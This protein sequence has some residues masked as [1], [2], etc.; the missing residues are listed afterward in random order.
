MHK[1]ACVFSF[2]MSS[3]VSCQKIVF[4]LHK[5]WSLNTK[6]TLLNFNYSSELRPG[7]VLK[8]VEEIYAASPEVIVIMDHKPH[9]LAL[10]TLL[11]EKY[12]DAKK[13]PRFIF[14]IFGDFTLYYLEW[15]SLSTLLKNYKVDFIVASPRQKLLIDKM[16]LPPMESY[17]CPFPVDSKEFNYAPQN[18]TAQRKSWGVTDKEM[19]FVF[20]GRLTLQKRIHT[21]IEQFA[22]VVR[23]P[24]YANAHLFLYGNTDDI[25]DP[26]LGK[27]ET[28]GE[29]F[30]LLD[31][32]YCSLE[33]EV[34]KKIHFMGNVSNHEL[35][36]VYQGADVLVN[37]SVHNDEDFGMSVAE[38]QASG[39]P[40]ILTDWGG[41]AGFATPELGAATIFVPVEIGMKSKIVSKLEVRRSLR[42]LLRSGPSRQRRKISELSLK[43]FDVAAAQEK[44]SEIYARKPQPFDD[45]SPL[46][47]KI[48]T[49]LKLHKSLYISRTSHITHTYREI[50]SAYVSGN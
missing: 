19:A 27:W 49:R 23:K 46:F 48:H 45:F 28:P 18:R 30:R 6:L 16:L 11:L 33:E 4:N 24:E 13:A 29:Y 47:K 38:A 25:A 1:V 32:L 10:L 15:E 2:K 3:W 39:L 12:K 41:L 40:S 31:K 42:Q 7:E 21:L 50:Y 20:T 22:A 34:K 14:H 5:A 35:A 26:F 9:P 37:L 44:L 36:A 43:K 8:L 17:V